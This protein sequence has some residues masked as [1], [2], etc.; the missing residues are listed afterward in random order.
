[1]K[2]N[3]YKIAQA[4]TLKK[5]TIQGKY[6]PFEAYTI[7]G[8]S[9]SI[10]EELKA[11]GFSWYGPKTI[12][13]LSS[14][15]MDSIKMQQLANLGL[16]L[17]EQ[18]TQ[19]ST[20]ENTNNSTIETPVV[21]VSPQEAQK[22]W[23]TEDEEMTAW[24][25]FP[26]NKNIYN[27]QIEII[28]DGKKYQCNLSVDRSYQPGKGDAYRKT[29]SREHKGLPKYIVNI[30]TPELNIKYAISKMSDKKWGTYNETEMIENY[31]LP[32]IEE[33]FINKPDSRLQAQ[34]RQFYDLSLRTPEY[35]KFLNDIGS[36]AV[37][38]E[39]NFQIDTEPYKGIFKVVVDDLGA[40][41]NTNHVYLQ[42]AVEHPLSPRAKTL[43]DVKL[44]GTYTI[45]DFNNRIIN[46]LETEKKQVEEIYVSYFK[47]FPYLKEQQ[48][49]S[50]ADFDQ[51]QEIIRSLDSDTVLKKVQQMGYIR[52]HKRQKQTGPGLTMGEEIKWVVD[53]KKIVND[54]YG[55]NNYLNNSPEFFYAVIAYYIHRKVR[56]IW[57]WSD[58]MLVSAMNDWERTAKKMGS[59]IDFRQLNSVVEKIGDDIVSKIFSGKT[60]E[61]KEREFS[62]WFYNGKDPS[63]DSVS[64]DNSALKAFSDFAES[65]GISPEGIESNLKKIYR[66]LAMAL[67]PDTKPLE[68]KDEFEGKFKKLQ[69]LYEEIPEQYKLSNVKD[70]LSV[71]S[72]NGFNWYKF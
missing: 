31:I 7:I 19:P 11:L 48:E 24:Y 29:K 62:D 43:G 37:V 38:P 55:G 71:L 30:A 56:G 10:K 70:L 51:I 13:W 65:Q 22:Q 41:E 50:K 49:T 66:M 20:N 35:K 60:K 15:K 64:S 72:K 28:V 26:I 46:H 17:S 2:I 6:G 27:K 34:I 40:E 68:Q 14:K 36:K 67:H 52:P 23:Q 69:Q 59:S 63:N 57:S 16:S 4:R 32:I 44:K 61:Q 39:F 54:A 12:W 1:M 8:D 58:M 3:W 53:S 45:K 9:R 47:S 42:T 33:K 18:Q 21:P 25:G 5:E